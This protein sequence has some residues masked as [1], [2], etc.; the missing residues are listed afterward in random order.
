MSR[1]EY[2]LALE[3]TTGKNLVVPSLNLFY[4]LASTSY[5]PSKTAIKAA[6]SDRSVSWNET[7]VIRRRPSR[8]PRWF[9][10][11]FFSTSKD[12]YLKIY[13]S[14]ECRPMPDEDTLV[15]TVKTTF[16]AL[17]AHDGEFVFPQIVNNKPA[18]SIRLEARHGQLSDRS[19]PRERNVVVFGDAGSGKSS[20]INALRH[21]QEPL[22]ETSNNTFGCTSISR[23][24]EVAISDRNFVL[25]DS[26]GLNE[27][28]G[29]T[30]PA[31]EAKKTLEE[32]SS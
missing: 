21:W 14:S 27:E 6:E 20:V 4:V 28:P 1:G 17:L 32:P 24:Y 26:A 7:I 3:V 13:A 30:V 12:V 8:F 22:V 15:A 25:F 2:V 10:P 5:G 16:E 19:R 23:P 31:A 9:L 18:P 11:F 29:G